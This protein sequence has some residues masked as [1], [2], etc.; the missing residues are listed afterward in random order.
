VRA[1]A[2]TLVALVVVTAAGAAAR[3]PPP[4]VLGPRSTTITRPVYRFV[5]RGAVSF[6]CAFDTKRL[7][8]CGRRYSQRL[9]F[10]RHTLRAQALGRDGRRSRTTVVPVRV[11]RRSPGL[12]AIPIAATI[13]VGR[14]PGAPATGF[15]AVWV[16]NSGDGTLVRIDPATNRVVARTP[17]SP[18]SRAGDFYDSAAVGHGSVWV[19]SDQHGLVARIDPATNRVVATIAVHSRPAEVTVTAD[20][21]WTAHFLSAAAT[22]IDAATNLA[23]ER[24]VSP[25]SLTGAAGDGSTIWLLS[26]SPQAV[27]RLDSGGRELARV[28]VTPSRAIKRSFLRAWWLAAGEGAIWATHPDYD[29]VGRIDPS[30]G[31]VAVTIP[32]T[33]GRLFGVAAGGGSAWA[34][35][36]RALLRID[37]RT[38]RVVGAARLPVGGDSGFTGVAAGEGGVWATGYDRGELYRMNG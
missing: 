8:R 22:R 32:V 10:G 7:H 23:T 5:A 25:A 33:L 36:D 37:L 26:T 11:F 4:R 29:V 35:T 27:I 19:S 16:P 9:S 2:I 30:S 21:V 31:R 18:P 6:R 17:Y 15:G 24:D 3:P 14:G 38:N 28:D 13:A 20:A 12:P 34:V 1:T